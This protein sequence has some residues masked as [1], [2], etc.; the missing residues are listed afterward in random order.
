MSVP[1]GPEFYQPK[2]VHDDAPLESV[3][4]EIRHHLL[5]ILDFEGLKQYLLDR[6]HLLSECWREHWVILISLWM[7]V[8]F[9]VWLDPLFKNTHPNNVTQ[10]L[11]SYKD[12]RSLSQHPSLK[13][14]FA[15]NELMSILSFHASVIVPLTQRYTDWALVN[16]A[17]ETKHM[18][19][20]RA[21]YR[22]QLYCNLFGVGHDSWE[23][24]RWDDDENRDIFRIFPRIFKTWEI[25]EITCIY[26]FAMKKFDRVFDDIRWDVHQ[27][28][29]KFEEQ[30]RPPT[31][32]GAFDF[33][34]SWTREILL[35][36]TISCGLKLLK[37]VLFEIKDHAHLPTANFQDNA[38]DSVTEELRLQELRDLGQEWQ[39][40]PPFRCDSIGH[41]SLPWTLTSMAKLLVTTDLYPSEKEHGIRFW[42]HMMWDAARLEYTGAKGVLLRKQ[43]GCWGDQEWDP[44]DHI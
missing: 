27:E 36:G 7:L 6:E 38:L 24:N 12:R 40:P 37:H 16:L 34:S 32:E 9:T 35:D 4:A 15:A 8:L 30:F 19:V 18:W 1:L 3:P 41:S 2:L 25:E 28:N 39:S 31:P 10:F 17:N 23:R 5:S 20:V 42:G 21:L 26:T 43:K 22:F 11:Q 14:M 13:E 33:D 29:P 44:L